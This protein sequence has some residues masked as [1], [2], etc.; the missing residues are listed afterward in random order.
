MKPAKLWTCP[1]CKRK[2]A[3]RNQRHACG[4]WTV[5]QRFAGRPRELRGLFD[6]FLK[7]LRESGPVR[8]HPA[9]TRIGFV[10]R[11]TFA[12]MT[13]MKDRLRVGLILSRRVESPRWVKVERYGPRCFGHYFN[14]TSSDDLDDELRGLAAEAYRVGMQEQLTRRRGRAR[15]IK[16]NP[17][18][19]SAAQ[20]GKA[21]PCGSRRNRKR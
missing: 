2:F 5:G 10:A 20:V 6:A 7:L 4:R 9:K 15:S 18:V 14:L 16:Q 8:L 3:A 19:G 1:R 12:N 11:M 21:L 13:V 17:A